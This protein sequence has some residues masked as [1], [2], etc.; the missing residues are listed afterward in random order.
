MQALALPAGGNTALCL[1]S[2]ETGGLARQPSYA[3]HA[4]NEYAVVTTDIRIVN[5]GYFPNRLS[6]TLR[7]GI[8]AK[9]Y[10]SVDI[11]SVR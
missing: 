11:L 4:H 5:L 9:G 3:M 8:T 1:L 10:A 7:D 2:N 6:H